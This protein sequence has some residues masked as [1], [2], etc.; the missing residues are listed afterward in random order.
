[1]LRIK[2]KELAEILGVSVGYSQVLL[3]RKGLKLTNRYLVEIID[4]ISQRKVINSP[5]N[6]VSVKE[7]PCPQ[8]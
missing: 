2:H 3:H 8:S 7:T 6:A 5:A 4:L 1:M